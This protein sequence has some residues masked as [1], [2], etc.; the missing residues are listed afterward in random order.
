MVRGIYAAYAWL[1]L[2]LALALLGAWLTGRVLTDRFHWSQ[3]PHWMPGVLVTP[4][5]AVLALLGGL[6]C[7]PGARRRG[8][9][10]STRADDSGQSARPRGALRRTVARAVLLGSLASMAYVLVVELRIDRVVMRRHAER[11]D[12]RV[13]AWNL[14]YKRE[15]P[16]AGVIERERPEIVLLANPGWRQQFEGVRGLVGEGSDVVR[17]G[18]FCVISSRPILAHGTT[19]L[20]LLGRR[21]TGDPMDYI[22]ADNPTQPFDRGRAMFVVLGGVG[23]ASGHAERAA[24]EDAVGPGAELATALPRGLVVW[25]IDMPSD[26]ALGRMA[27]ARTA[28]AAIAAFQGPVMLRDGRESDDGRPLTRWMAREGDAV[29]VRG[30]PTPDLVVGDFN[31]PRGA[32]SL[33]VLTEGL[34]SCFARGGRGYVATWPAGVPLLHLDQAFAGRGLEAISYRT[35]HAEMVPHRAQ[36]IDLRIVGDR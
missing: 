16:V 22:E 34:S 36:V 10:R 33:D 12:L 15:A 31:V 8:R 14:V 5:C 13:L 27:S 4:A 25:I 17:S 18:D 30:F 23:A 11:A 6:G 26:P 32:A 28:A 24:G 2:L 19:T 35:V 21:W 20:G 29:G 1:A 3:Y 7:G 9:G